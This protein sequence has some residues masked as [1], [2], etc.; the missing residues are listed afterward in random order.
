MDYTS[1]DIL[2]EETILGIKSSP[3]RPRNTYW[4]RKQY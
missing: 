1:P 2:P 4:V 3:F